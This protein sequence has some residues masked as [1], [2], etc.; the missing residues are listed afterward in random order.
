MKRFVL[1]LSISACFADNTEIY[2]KAY[3][4]G[5]Q[6]QFNLNL[7]TNSTIN[8]YGYANKFESI[9]ANN[10]NIGNASAKNMYDN[11]YGD[12]ADPNYLFKAGV[13]EI[14]DCQ[15]EKDP[16][17]TTLNKYGDKDTQRQIQA[18]TRG[19]SAKYQISVTPDPSDTQCMISKRKVPINQTISTCV[20]G[21]KEHKQCDNFIIPSFQMSCTSS[22]IISER[23]HRVADPTQG[24][25]CDFLNV[26]LSCD[27]N[28]A[29]KVFL[30][31]EDCSH[32]GYSS[33]A[34]T[35]FVPTI[36][37]QAGNV[38]LTPTWSQR[39]DGC[40]GNNILSLNF[41]YYCIENGD[42]SISFVASCNNYPFIYKNQ[43]NFSNLTT[44][45]YVYTYNKGCN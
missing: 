16:R 22:Q 10:A 36:H 44:K 40:G 30:A 25:Q 15:N 28:G 23:V 39:E 5:E 8:S 26:K 31:T 3:K 37:Q 9:V 17:C 20:A 33:S 42:C 45:K 24:Q 1:F 12:K 7:N 2:N 35:T 38:T 11:T 13:K 27:T 34:T 41:N 18:Y 14:A 4:F 6:H 32:S 19:F 21:L 29:Y 43:F